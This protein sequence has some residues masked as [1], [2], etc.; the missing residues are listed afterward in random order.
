MREHCITYVYNVKSD[1]GVIHITLSE[2]RQL[3]ENLYFDL[4]EDLIPMHEMQM[5]DDLPFD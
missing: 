4:L 1:K 5:D 2:N 3:C